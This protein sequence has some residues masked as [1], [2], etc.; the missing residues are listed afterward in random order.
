MKTLAENLWSDIVSHTIWEG[1][2]TPVGAVHGLRHRIMIDM[3]AATHSR[4]VD[5]WPV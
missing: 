3:V 1:Q 5:E 2:S 4:E